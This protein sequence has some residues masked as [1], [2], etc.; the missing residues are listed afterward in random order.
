MMW[1]LLAFLSAALLDSMMYLRT[2]VE[3][4]CGYSGII[5]EYVVL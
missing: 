3:G 2:V 5:S 1:L 4:Q